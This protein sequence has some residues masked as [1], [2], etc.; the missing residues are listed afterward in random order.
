MPFL[1]SFTPHVALTGAH[2][3]QASKCSQGRSHRERLKRE[4]KEGHRAG[5]STR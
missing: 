5:G 2:G 1:Q 3:S 4:R